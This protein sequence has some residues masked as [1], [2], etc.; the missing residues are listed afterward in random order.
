MLARAVRE[1]LLPRLQQE[2][3][4][5]AAVLGEGHLLE[6]KVRQA[7]LAVMLEQRVAQVAA[8]ALWSDR[9]RR[10]LV[11]LEEMAV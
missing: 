3:V 4:L 11:A 2:L 10:Q 1:Q 8:A 7:Q 5:A 6:Y 9:P